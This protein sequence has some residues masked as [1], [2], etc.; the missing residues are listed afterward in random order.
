MLAVVLPLLSNQQGGG[1]GDVTVMCDFSELT[2]LL[3][4]VPEHLAN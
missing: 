1:G 2:V 4:L 3:A